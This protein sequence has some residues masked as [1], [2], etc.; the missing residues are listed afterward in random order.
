MTL[1]GMGGS[2]M[3]VAS[4]DQEL[5]KGIGMIEEGRR[6]AVDGS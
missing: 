4:E 6:G 1:F 2:A 3:A 5:E